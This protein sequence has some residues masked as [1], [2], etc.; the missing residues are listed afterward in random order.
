MLELF[1]FDYV[2]ENKRKSQ[3]G[4]PEQRML[5]VSNIV[6]LETDMWASNSSPAPR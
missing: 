5:L 4:S 6:K 1:T 2:L 3:Q